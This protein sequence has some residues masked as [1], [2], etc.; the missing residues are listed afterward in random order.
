MNARAA[1]ALRWAACLCG[2]AGLTVGAMPARA[3]SAL[4]PP[5]APA[6][7]DR[8]IGGGNLAPDVSVGDSYSSDTS[9]LARSVR[10]DALAST[11]EAQGANPAPTIHENGI[12]ANGQWETSSYGTWSADLGVRIGASAESEFTSLAN[13]YASFTLRQ[14]GMPFDGGWQ[15]DTGLG[16]L[17]TPL[18]DLARQQPRFILASGAMFGAE[19]EWHGPSGAQIVAG[20]GEPGVFEGI[21]VPTFATLGG[22]TG[23]VGAQWSPAP[24]WTVG[25]VFAGARDA[26][27]YYQPPGSILISPEVAN[28]GISSDTALLSAAWQAAANRVQINVIDGTLDS[29]GNSFGVWVDG[30]HSQNAYTQ[31]YGAFRIEP[32]LA[33]GN[34]LIA[35]D[36]EGGYYRLGYQ[37]RRWVADFGVDE[38]RS[39]SGEGANS[40]FLNGDARYQLSRDTGVGGV[41]NLLLASDGGRH[42]AWSVQ[43]Y[44]DNANRLGSSR[45]QLGYATN[46]Q[47]DDVSAS[48]QQTWSVPAGARLAT[49]VAVDRLSAAALLGLPAQDSTVL[50]LAA[51]GGGN[52]TARLSLD[53]S[54]QWAAAVQ[55]RAA[56]STSADV[57]LSY[58]IAHAWQLLLTYYENR[59]GSWTP[60]VVTSPLAPPVPTLQASQGQ[61][62]FFLTLR[63]QYAR[64]S[65]FVPLGGRPGSGSGRLTGVVYLDANDNGRFDAGETGVANVTV[66]LDGRFSTR[67]DANGR[68]DFPAVAAGHHVVS[69]QSDNLPLPWML[70]GEGRTEVDVGTRDRTDVNI[71]AVRIR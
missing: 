48:L 18:I 30:S 7:Q 53:G 29:N 26:N 43:G 31:S 45:V 22:T 54:V 38:A 23:T 12:V 64:G 71:G 70:P 44:V 60:L 61:Q 32:N 1:H 25:G 17:N 9:G 19:T 66:V 47:T 28:E 49:S 2:L 42:T 13:N 27:L 69:V 39:V 37:T 62:G 57:S 15:A 33:W 20:G 51:Y 3:Q 67:T 5:P 58:E 14:H 6:Y 21:K 11:L 46:W 56:P 59:L 65:H 50:R 34:Q 40:T 36:V 16:D 8:L 41:A 10:I 63:Y 68:F 52:V 35:S 4:G 24:A 55:G